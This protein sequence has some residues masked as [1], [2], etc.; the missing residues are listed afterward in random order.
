MVMETA[1]KES[2]IS[3]AISVDCHETPDRFDQ[4]FDMATDVQFI[5][6]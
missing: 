1:L 6:G 5:L 2:G 3:H 4:L